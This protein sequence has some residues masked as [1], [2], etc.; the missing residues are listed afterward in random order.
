MF[1]KQLHRLIKCIISRI[2]E[3]IRIQSK[4]MLNK[5]TILLGTFI[6]LTLL[7]CKEKTIPQI[8]MAG[9][10][11]PGY[12]PL[13][14]AASLG[15]FDSN[16]RMLEFPSASEIL[17]AFKNSNLEIAALTLDEVIYLSSEGFNGKIVLV[18]DVSNGADVLL[19]QK[20]ITSAS[21]LKGKKIGVEYTALGAY[22]LARFLE[23]NH[24]KLKEITM[25]PIEVD[26]H[27]ELFLA[28]KVDAVITFEPTKSRLLQKGANTIFSSSMIKGEIV[29]VLFVR[30][31]IYQQYPDTISHIKNGWYKSLDFMNK[32]FSVAALKMKPRLNLSEEELKNVFKDIPLGDKIMNQQLLETTPPPLLQTLKKVNSVMLENKIIKNKIYPENLFK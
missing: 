19:A 25:V 22:I 4:Y 21:Q 8:R 26:S 30:E 31:D 15:Y 16:I 6:I 7:T 17:R 27:E 12:E 10:P 14:T 29:D 1:F 28:H 32:N 9:I 13:Y 24:I 20:N 11:W 5:K 2:S 3:K 18:L 23:I